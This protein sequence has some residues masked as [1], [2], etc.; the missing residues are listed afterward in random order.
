VNPDFPEMKENWPYHWFDSEY[1]IPEGALYIYLA[2]A[3]DELTD[4]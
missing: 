1:V 4:E 2:N 3:M